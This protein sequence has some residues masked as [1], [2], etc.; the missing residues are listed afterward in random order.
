MKK[1]TPEQK[2]DAAKSAIVRVGD[3]GRG[4]IVSAGEYDR[5]IVTAA[6]CLPHIPRPHLANGTTELT[7]PKII[8]A[9]SDRKARM[10]WGELCVA[11]ITDD[12]AVLRAPDDGDPILNVECTEY[13]KFTKPAIRIARPP[14]PA[15]YL[16]VPRKD[17]AALGLQFD[18]DPM[19]AFILS[20]DGEWQSCAVQNTGRFLI[21]GDG[22]EN[23][24]SGM[25]GSPIIN[26]D[27]AAIGLVSTGDRTLNMHPSLMDC[28]PPWLLCELDVRKS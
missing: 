19:A 5:Y 22:G 15:Q 13:K 21:I 12:L 4:F 3:G 2:R 9:L 28:L 7:F 16:N 10:I 24:K 14:A 25:S 18:P 17:L 8:G 27:G 11:S 6:H 23:I 26:I 1:L 20:L